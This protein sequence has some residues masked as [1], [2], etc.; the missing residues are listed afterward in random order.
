MTKNV[1]LRMEEALLLKARK[2]ALEQDKSLSQW[3]VDV[4]MAAISQEPEYAE[5][6]KRALRTLRK[7]FKLGGRAL[8]REESHDH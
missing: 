1:T 3:V 8:S 6:R 2:L 4:I 7:G 5:Q